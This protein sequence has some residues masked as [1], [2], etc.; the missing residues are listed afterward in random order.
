MIQ[1]QTPRKQA[2]F[3]DEEHSLFPLHVWLIDD[4]IVHFVPS[5][6][7]EESQVHLPSVQVKPI[8]LLHGVN[9]VHE[10]LNCIFLTLN[11]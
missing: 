3:L 10:L 6:N 9:C 1:L 2:R 4:W 11:I 5:K 7:I 8:K